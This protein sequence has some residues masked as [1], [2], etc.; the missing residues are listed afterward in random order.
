MKEIELTRGKKALVDDEDYDWLNAKKWYAEK[1]THTYYARKRENNI[2]ISMQNI[3]LNVSSPLRV[4]HIDGNGLNNQRS[5]LRIATHRQNMINIGKRRKNPTSKYKG[6]S[7]DKSRNK[8]TAS[9]GVNYKC[10]S[11]GRYNTEEEA[12]IAYNEAAKKTHGEFARL[13]II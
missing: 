5:N 3:I 10:I 13:N 7:F 9:M 1:F 2:L 11:L 4:D 6:V 12:A 8:W